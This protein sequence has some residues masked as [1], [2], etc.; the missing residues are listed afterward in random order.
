MTPT[1][2]LSFVNPAML[3]G[4]ALLALPIA[5]H[6]LH[7]RAKRSIVFPSVE[8][9]VETRAS[10]SSLFR[11]R[12]WL[13]LFLRCLAVLL[14][15]GAFARPLLDAEPTA[16]ADGDRGGTV[17]LVI[18]RSASTRARVQE[19]SAMGMLRTMAIAELDALT[20]G[21][22][23]VQVVW[24]DASPRAAFVQP[25]TNHDLVRREIDQTEAT[26]ERADL[27]GAIALAGQRLAEAAGERRLVVISDLQASNWAEID[28]SV[29]DALPREVEVAVPNFDAAETFNA[30]IASLQF[31]PAMSVVGQPLIVTAEVHNHAPSPRRIE[32]R[33]DVNGREYARRV[34][35]V[36]PWSSG[37]AVFRIDPQRPGPVE[38]TAAIP[39]DSLAVDNTRHAVVEVVD[40]LPVLLVSDD[41]PDEPG[42]ASFFLS[43][44]LA[45]RASERDRYRVVHRACNEV[46]REDVRGFAL[47]VVGRMLA[48]PPDNTVA[49]V[50]RYLRAGG[51]V[52]WFAPEDGSLEPL[53]RLA[54]TGGSTDHGT[55]ET[56]ASDGEAG[57]GSP[58]ALPGAVAPAGPR[59]LGE[60]DWQHPLLRRYDDRFR[61]SLEAVTFAPGPR[62][63]AGEEAEVLLRFD[64]GSPAA[65]SGRVGQGR[66]VVAGFSPA[67]EHSD[68]ATHGGF[69][70]LMQGLAAD[71]L[72]QRSMRRDT[73]VGET[74]RMR[75]DEV[76]RAGPSPRVLGPSGEPV[77]E[78]IFRGDAGVTATVPRPDESGFYRL[79]QA[80]EPLARQSVNV[81]PREGD[82]RRIAPSV[83]RQRMGEAGEGVTRKGNEAES[84]PLGGTPIWGVL[85]ALAA[86]ALGVEMALT[87]W[88]RR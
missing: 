12:R 82:P 20:P 81:D 49:A 54:S 22:D 8:L 39:D 88:W 50:G 41:G 52:L 63:Q 26:R 9:L 17:V 61:L 74:L 70:T 37:Q 28:A 10:Q 27:R 16:A 60:G 58:L 31:E 84:G 79:V 35:T 7:R 55:G 13:L 71:L 66:L 2:A 78:A 87:A 30:T 23:R 34:S 76:N 86:A 56:R 4:A 45:P 5:A 68:I 67:R 6:L 11:L 43:R 44:S 62:L 42:S 75:S 51:S 77:T 57:A 40:R 19:V 38:L 3:G 32:V 29:F 73:H 83:L 80:G 69:V 72:P 65:V 14:L 24:A 15:V 36:S 59:R 85:A 21:R 25:T 47:I 1:L 53:G 18:D 46:V 48:A 33:L 64:D